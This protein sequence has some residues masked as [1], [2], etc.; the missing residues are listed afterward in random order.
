M[1]QVG[2]KTV[3]L[4]LSHKKSALLNDYIISKNV[5]TGYK[6]SQSGSLKCGQ[7]ATFLKN[8]EHRKA[9]FATSCV[10]HKMFRFMLKENPVIIS[11]K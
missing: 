4:C 6:R 10:P 1:K 9:W 5:Q 8:V 7:I 11:E 2:T 3:I